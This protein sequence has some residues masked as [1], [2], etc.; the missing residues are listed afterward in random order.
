MSGPDEHSPPPR[1]PVCST[2]N[3][4][5]VRHR[6]AKCN[7]PTNEDRYDEGGPYRQA[8]V[9]CEVAEQEAEGRLQSKH[10]EIWPGAAAMIGA[11]MSIFALLPLETPRI[12]V[13]ANHYE[14]SV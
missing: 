7:T 9:W 4:S 8:G 5:T 10:A 11:M 14:G 2:S 12:N 13:T 3:S 1:I 6:E